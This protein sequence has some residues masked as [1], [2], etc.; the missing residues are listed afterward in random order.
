ML[1]PKGVKGLWCLWVGVLVQGSNLGGN[2]DHQRRPLCHAGEPT[3][4]SVLQK[5]PL[6]QNTSTY[7]QIVFDDESVVMFWTS[8][9]VLSCGDVTHHSLSSGKLRAQRWGC[10]Q[11]GLSA[12]SLGPL[13]PQSRPSC[14][15]ALWRRCSPAPP[16]AECLFLPWRRTELPGCKAWHVPHDNMTDV[17]SLQSY[18]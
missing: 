15:T 4:P 16:R 17:Y 2:S 6:H 8:R 10:L 13:L 5:G 14:P 18:L 9:F 11:W 1:K 3:E 7:L 12:L